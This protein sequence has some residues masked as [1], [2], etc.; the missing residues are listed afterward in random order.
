MEDK[1][2]H[3]A[4]YTRV[5]ADG[6]DSQVNG[7]DLQKAYYYDM[8]KNRFGVEPIGFYVDSLSGGSEFQRLMDDCR[9]GRIDKIITKSI[10]RF[11]QKFGGFMPVVDELRRLGVSVLFELEGLDTSISDNDKFLQMLESFVEA[12]SKMYSDNARECRKKRGGSHGK[13]SPVF[14]Y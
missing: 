9:A 7:L 6:C 2:M 12:E 11:K 8:C 5:K 4:I 14:R 10:Y 1:I 3:I 13:K